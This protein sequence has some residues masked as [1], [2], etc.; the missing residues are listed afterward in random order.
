MAERGCLLVVDDDPLNRI[1]LG[2]ALEGLGYEVRAVAGGEEA[3]AVLG[4]GARADAVLLDVMMPDL[5]GTEVLARLKSDP[6]LADVP[7]LMVSALDDTSQVV[8]CLELGADDYVTKPFDPVVLRARLNAALN[9]KLLRDLERAYTARVEAEEERSRRLL[10]NILP[11]AVANRLKDR[12]SLIADAYEDA[13][14]LFADLVGFTALAATMSPAATVEL[15]NGIFS[16]FD[17]LAGELGV[18]KIKTMGDGYLAVG[19]LPE[20][21]EGHT[22][23]AAEL[24]LGMM[25]AL[26]EAS[27]QRLQMRVGIHCGPVV[28]GVIGR[29]K[30]SYDLW[31]DTVNLASRLES[32]A[33]PGRIQVSRAV[34]DRLAGRY[35]LVE[36]GEVHLRGRGSVRAWYL[37]AARGA[38]G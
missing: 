35:D 33:E 37:N 14:V 28:A 21:V 27:G 11:A 30:F 36:R 15:L 38:A 5:D 29:R 3:L 20:P 6:D 22:E 8:R 32:H 13:T 26:G 23:A 1:V 25:A 7:V 9:K 19:G 34:Y 10:L 24:A 4:S 16:R 18:E 12:T 17:H 2:R 31:G